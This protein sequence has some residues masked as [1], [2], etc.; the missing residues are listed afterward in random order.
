MFKCSIDAGHQAL[1][2]GLFVAGGAVD[3]TRE[4]QVFDQVG[5]QDSFSW[6][7]GK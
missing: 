6:V 4:K 1:A 2:G 7:G 3:L 5:L